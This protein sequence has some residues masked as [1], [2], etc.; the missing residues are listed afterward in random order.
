[1][2][3]TD[4]TPPGPDEGSPGEEGAPEAPQDSTVI[5]DS[6]VDENG[7]PLTELYGTFLDSGVPDPPFDASD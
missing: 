6:V 2:E 5:L 4:R 1:M 3:P 7:N